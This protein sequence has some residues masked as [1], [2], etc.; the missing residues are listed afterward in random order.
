MLKISRR[1][2][3][4]EEEILPPDM[5]PPEILTLCFVNANK[6][7]VSTL[8]FPLSNVCPVN[9]RRGRT[10]DFRRKSK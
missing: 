6:E 7:T 3:K 1:I 9:R 2:E 8:E 5:G 10:G 4:L